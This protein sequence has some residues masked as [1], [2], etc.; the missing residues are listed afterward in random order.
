MPSYKG[1]AHRAVIAA[2]FVVAA[3]LGTATGIVF[4]YAGD[5][6]QI[7]GLDDYAPSTI[8]R[9]YGAHG[10]VVGEFAIERREI[11]PYER[12]SPKLEQAILAAEDDGFNEHFGL[13]ISRIAITAI[14]DIIHR[15][16]HGASTLTQ[17][18]AR[19]LFLTD[20]KTPERKIREAL[21]AIQIEKRYTKR[22]IF[23]LYCNQMYFGHGVYGVESASRLYF[24]KS[25]KDL[26]LEEAALI[27]GILQGNV[28]QSPYVNREAAMRRRNYTLGRM[29]EVGF[30]TPAEADDAKKKPIVVRPEQPG[31]TS[32]L[33][34]YFLE[35]VRRELE[36]RYGAKQLY[37]NGLS[38]HT[39]LDLRLQEAA[40]QALTEGLRRIDKRRGFRKPKRNIIA[41][42]HAID[43]YK[44]PRWDRS[45]SVGQIVPA[46]VTAVD[47]ASIQLRAGA[48]KI[49]ID[50]K[51]YAW[52]NKPAAT[53]LVA[54]GDLVEARLLTVTDGGATATATLEQPPEVEGAV[55]ALDNRTGQVLT[56]IGGYSFDRSKFNRATQAFR[57]VGSSFKPIVYTTA[58]DS[59]YTPVTLL[60]DTPVSFSSG[61][62]QPAYAPLNYD[63]QFEG[64]ITLRR[65]LEQSRNVPAVRVMDQLGPK[66]VIA[67]ARR[68]GIESQIPPYLAVALGAAEA[69]LVEMTSAYSVYPNQGVRMRPYSV[70]KVT[71][72]EGN[73]LEENRPE[74][75][76]AIRADTAYVMTNLLRGVVQRGTATKAAA[77]NWPVG[78]KTGTTDDYSD[79]WFVGFDPDITIGVWVGYDQKRSMGPAGTGAESALPIWV[80]I[81]KAWIN[82]RTE[83]PQFEAPGNIVFV[84]VDR[85]SGNPAVEGT[86][87]AIT[88]S[89]IA[90][91]QP[92]SGFRE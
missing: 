3:I 30:I 66:Q 10:E 82:A 47:A 37:E 14:S 1:L 61:A 26:T 28:R 4:A 48:M 55:L 9:V 87:N 27:A 68:L 45:M 2:L 29:A 43:A 84:S 7:S 51:G 58:I 13:S 59:G 42:G 52:T 79:A 40:T 63:R 77:L 86:P 50:K 78:G 74:P 23:T 32:S 67:Y 85:G 88:E 12:I 56:M 24:G 18:L 76:D 35:D 21:L 60:M 46:L 53:A 54:R 17:Q 34:P 6:P 8:S 41:E 73:V 92:G 36:S 91:T 11:I 38:I 22:E 31:Q 19:K 15:R 81:M 70:L 44:Q 16:M 65:A 33:A 80:D 20:D 75:K 71:D 72:R 64:P 49:A 62:G 83:P 89:F 69:T 25:A 90:G 39:A 5:L 57:Q